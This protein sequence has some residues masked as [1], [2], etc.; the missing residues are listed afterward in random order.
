[1]QR[2]AQERIL[3]VAIK[4]F[5]EQGYAATTTAD[6]ARTAKVTQP[7]VHH[8]FG[9][10]DGL[11]HAAVDR[12]FADMPGLMSEEDGEGPLLSAAERFVRMVAQRPQISAIL[13]H[14]S[15]SGGPRL[16]YLLKNYMKRPMRRAV[17]SIKERQAAG[18]IDP[19]LRPELLLIF[20]VGAAT[21]LFNVPAL[22]KEVHGVDV[23]SEETREDFLAVMRAVILGVMRPL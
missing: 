17:A 19:A 10:K 18:V 20:M 2:P 16:D 12:V 21:H 3:D 5:A 4:S 8:H 9:S 1:M 23:R 11:W 15:V 13:A 7:L 6:V 22:M 14:E